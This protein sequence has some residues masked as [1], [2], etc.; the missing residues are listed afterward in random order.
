MVTPQFNMAIDSEFRRK[1][2]EILMDSSFWMEQG[3]AGS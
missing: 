2:I 1:I 3:G